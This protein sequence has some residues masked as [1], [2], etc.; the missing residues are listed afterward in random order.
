MK[1]WKLPAAIGLLGLGGSIFFAVNYPAVES[2]GT[3]VRLPV[4]HG[5]MTWANLMVFAALIVYA[6]LFLVKKDEKYYRMGEAT[7]WTAIAMWFAGTVLGFLAAM[8]TWDFTGSKTPAIELL[9]SDPRL[10]AQ[11]CIALAGLVM[12]I[13]PLIFEKQRSMSVADIVFPA[14]LFVALAWAMNAGKALH[15]DSPVLNSDEIIIK[16]LFFCMVISDMVMAA[17][18][19]AA[20]ASFRTK[21]LSGAR[22]EV[23]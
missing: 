10:I 18:F 19:S 7:R 23:R 11:V 2:I 21:R 3:K 12:I 17:G 13:L 15:P 16:L 9:M 1:D 6:I 4:F 22:A 20:I 14:I 8:N 5:A